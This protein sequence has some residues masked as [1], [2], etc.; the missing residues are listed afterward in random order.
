VVS[1][2][3]PNYNHAAY[4]NKRIE[5]I[6]NQTYQDFELIIL[7][8][9]STDNSKEIVEG[10]KNHPKVTRI[11]YNEKNSGNTFKQWDKGF[12][13]AKGEY[14]WI[15]ESDDY[16]E[17]GL[18][19]EL[20]T[21]LNKDSETVLAFCQSILVTPANEIIGVTDSKYLSQTVNGDD[22][23]RQYM[24]GGNKIPNASMAI[25]KKD[26]CG[27]MSDEY[28]KM[29]YCGDWL[30]WVNICFKGKVYISGKYLNYY[31]RHTNNV[32]TSATKKGYDFLEGNKIFHFILQSITVDNALITSAL[33][34][35][36]FRYLTL[37]K[38]FLD[39]KTDRAVVKSLLGLHPLMKLLFSI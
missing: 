6:L 17:L 24:L 12:Q 38:K 28:K 26:F 34:M 7:D 3:L 8:D 25:F 22:F 37:K 30:F 14:I 13:L 2:I 31:L 39:K 19:E 11:V 32:T 15:A 9:C 21:G 36:V 10:Y 18:L 33:R 29:E 23:V 20:I 1:V 35:K 5:S 27:D 16:C 4:L